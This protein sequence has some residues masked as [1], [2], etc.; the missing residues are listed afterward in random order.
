M[1]V[2]ACIK[3]EKFQKLAYNKIYSMK[4]KIFDFSNNRAYCDKSSFILEVVFLLTYN[5]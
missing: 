3:E 4:E 2:K 1:L 5:F